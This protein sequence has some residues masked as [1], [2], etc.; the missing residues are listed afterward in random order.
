MDIY[1][2]RTTESRR[3]TYLMLGESTSAVFCGP[4]HVEAAAHVAELLNKDADAVFTIPGGN[5]GS[6]CAPQLVGRGTALQR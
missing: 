5:H 1:T 4:D 6:P 3:Q 2:T